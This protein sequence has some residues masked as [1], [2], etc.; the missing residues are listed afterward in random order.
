[1]NTCKS[2]NTNCTGYNDGECISIENCADKVT[3]VNENWGYVQKGKDQF[4]RT[5]YKCVCHKC[6]RIIVYNRVCHSKPMCFPCKRE[7][8]YTK[9]KQRQIDAT[10]KAAEEAVKDFAKYLID[11][12][13]DVVDECAEYLRGGGEDESTNLQKL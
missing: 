1:M 10:S 2:S 7:A 11:R 5:S 3:M 4:G 6:G 12:G 9:A 13:I 8:E